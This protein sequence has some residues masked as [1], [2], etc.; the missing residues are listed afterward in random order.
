MS[1]KRNNSGRDGRNG[2]EGTGEIS[3][4]R[5]A[6]R[7]HVGL[8][9]TSNQDFLAVRNLHDRGTL[10]VVADGMGGHQGGERASRLAADM[11]IA[12]IRQGKKAGDELLTD[13]L[14]AANDA[15][16]SEASHNPELKGMGTT[17]VAALLSEGRGKVINLGDSRAYL[18]HGGALSRIT[19]DHSMVGDLLRRGEIT[20]EEA[21]NHPR[22][23]VLTRAVGIEGRPQPDLFPVELGPGD[24]LLLCSDGLHGMVDDRAIREILEADWSLDSR[25]DA[26]IDAALDAGGKD[27]VTVLLAE[28]ADGSVLQ[29]SGPPTDPGYD[30]D[31]EWEDYDD[32]DD[33]ED[34]KPEPRPKGEGDGWV[35]LLIVV[36]IGLVGWWVWRS[37]FFGSGSTPPADSLDIDTTGLLLDSGTQLTP[38]D[39]VNDSVW[40]DS[41]SLPG[42]DTLP[43]QAP[44]RGPGR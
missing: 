30:A 33:E 2:S 24:V 31:D 41:L 34:W 5:I 29:G 42:S 15:V 20:E 14:A 39:M 37:D 40:S 44:G 38:S 22:R 4:L 12:H 19:Q 3:G 17:L 18:L 9:R 10:L 26:L 25:C 43:P 35:Y 8:R 6:T 16:L 21:E 36:I 32:D 13:A 11:F 23:N 27:N 28:P 7:T 1:N